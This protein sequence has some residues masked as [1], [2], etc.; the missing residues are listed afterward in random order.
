MPLRG[1]VRR[2]LNANVNARISKLESRD[3][4]REHLSLGA[5]RAAGEGD[6]G[7]RVIRPPTMTGGDDDDRQDRSAKLGSHDGASLV[8][9]DARS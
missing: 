8:R 2:V 9:L 6:D 1:V 5:K 7:T 3:L 4:P